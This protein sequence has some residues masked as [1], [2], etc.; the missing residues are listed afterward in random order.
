MA[1]IPLRFSF[2]L[3]QFTLYL[4]RMI[5]V[6][7]DSVFR[8]DPPPPPPP[9]LSLSLSLKSARVTASISELNIQFKE[10]TLL[11]ALTSS[12]FNDI[13]KIMSVLKQAMNRGINPLYF[14]FPCTMA[15]SFAFMLPLATP[16]NAIVFAVGHL[17]VKDMVG[18]KF[19]LYRYGWVTV[20]LVFCVTFRWRWWWLRLFIFCLLA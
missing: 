6:N 17:E 19:E 18:I 13:F 1:V 15:T 4:T 14:L 5:Q 9:H 11:K 8:L 3:S 12:L 10:C 2:W 7:T 16:P 20:W